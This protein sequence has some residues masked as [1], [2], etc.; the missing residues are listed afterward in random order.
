MLDRI[1]GFFR[2]IGQMIGRWA[3][4]FFAWAFWP[5]LAAHG[6]YQRR[7]WMIRLPVIAFVALLVVLYGYFF[8]QTQVWS[9]FN[10][11]F[12]D[13]YRLSE[14][15]VAAGQEVPVAEGANATAPKTCQ[16]SAIVDVAADLTDFNVNQNAW[17]S[18]M[19]LYKMGFFG[20]D[21]DHTPFLDNKAS[22]QRGVNQAVRRTSAELV[23]TLG[24]VRGTSGINNDLQSA[25]GNLQ[26]D[27]NSWYFGLNPFG[28]KT[29]TPSYYRSAIGSLR[30]FNTDL[31]LCNVIFDG[32]ADNLMQ[33]ID[34]IANDLGGTSDMLAE[35]SENHNRGWFD[36]RADDR[37]W[38]AYGQLYGYYAIMAAAQADFS[39]V[40][41]E[42]NLGA[43]WGGTMRQFQSALRIQPAII[44]NG[45]E[46]GWIMP[47]H[48]ATMGFYIL[49]VRSNLVEV[50]S[51][52]DR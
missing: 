19:L 18:S 22:F 40:L 47:S 46:D 13:Q 52:L 26:F 48:L 33:F 41:A 9:N 7:S 14:R 25:R 10:T 32:R 29:P 35:R 17:I 6:W 1:A 16:R 34:R 2:L 23:D 38:F 36:T 50:R 15:K 51:V 4:L 20:I 43:I 24:R 8:W 49:R 39:Q 28:P 3:R 31:A 30:K 21:W 42:R 37:F 11:A 27:E 5:F 44:S 12:V 45:R